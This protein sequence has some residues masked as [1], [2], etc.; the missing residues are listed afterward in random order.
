MTATAT[1][2][3]SVTETTATTYR[4]KTNLKRFVVYELGGVLDPQ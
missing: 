1:T 4:P 3:T 2:A